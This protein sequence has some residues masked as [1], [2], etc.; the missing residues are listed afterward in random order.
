MKKI[1]SEIKYLFINPSKIKRI[2]TSNNYYEIVKYFTFFLIILVL[3]ALLFGLI[4]FQEAKKNISKI[5]LDFVSSCFVIPIYEEI[6][7]RVLLKKN[8]LNF[9]LFFSVLTLFSISWI[10][11]LDT[12]IFI[13]ISLIIYVIL[14]KKYKVEEFFYN[15]KLQLFLIYFTTILFGIIHIVNIK[16]LE[17]LDSF[18]IV[19]ILNK[20]LIGF[21]LCFLRLKFGMLSS[22]SFHS[23]I[24]II[25][26][27]LK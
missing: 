17:C 23:I 8:K 27:Y 7:F 10:F 6:I 14:K 1:L 22:I 24:N 2:K 19:Y 5:D 25:S 16:N 3:F 13:V 21:V 20:I 9:Y 26:F 18:N 12:S 15:Q 4:F 11:L